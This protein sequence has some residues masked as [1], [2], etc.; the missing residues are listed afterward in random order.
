M[1]YEALQDAR[2]RRSSAFALAGPHEHETLDTTL[3]K[4][5]GRQPGDDEHRGASCK[6]ARDL[7]EMHARD[8]EEADILP[9]VAKRS[10]PAEL[11]R[12]G[13]EMLAETGAD[14]AADPAARRNAR[15]RGVTRPRSGMRRVE[16]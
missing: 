8:E 11:D 13:A 16:C 5:L 7:F 9:L 12:L 3:D 2:R 4:L 15:S 10:T 6:V 14:S 1:L